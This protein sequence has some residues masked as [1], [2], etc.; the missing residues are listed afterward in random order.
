MSVRNPNNVHAG[1]QVNLLFNTLPP[2]ELAEQLT[3]LEY[4]AF[5]RI[6]VSLHGSRV[7]TFSCPSFGACVNYRYKSSMINLCCVVCTNVWVYNLF[8]YV[9]VWFS[10][11]NK[12]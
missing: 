10:T 5:R 4:K 1:K 9:F 2:S 3:F 8:N 12:V 11:V 6:T 7:L